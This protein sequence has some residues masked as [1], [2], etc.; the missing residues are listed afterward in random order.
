TDIFNLINA[1][2]PSKVKTGLRLRAAHEVS[3][4]MAIASRV[5]DMEDPDAATE[6]SRTPS[7]IEKSSLD[8]DNKNP[9]SPM[10]EELSPDE[11]AATMEPRSSKNHSRRVND[12]AYANAPPKVLRKYYAS[13][14]PEQSTRG[15][16]SLSTMRL[17]AGATFIIPVDTKNVNDPDS[18]SYA[19]SQPHPEQSMTYSYEISTGN[20]ATMEVQD[21]RSAESEGSGKSTSSPSM[22]G[23]PGDIYQPG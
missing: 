5:I 7:A 9:S 20:V 8:F 18:L 21:T 15:V 16:K 11:E 10:T 3:L 13:V 1:P 6:S 2:N 17:V 14:R 4:L 23:S 22:V 12:G 19:E